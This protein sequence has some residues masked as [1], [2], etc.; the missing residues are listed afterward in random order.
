MDFGHRAYATEDPRDGYPGARSAG[1][2]GTRGDDAYYGMSRRKEEAVHAEQGFNSSLDRRAAD[3]AATSGTN[4][5][6]A[7]S[8]RAGQGSHS[9]ESG[10]GV[11]DGLDRSGKGEASGARAGRPAPAPARA[12]A[13]S[14]ILY[15]A[16][17]VCV[18]AG[19]YISWHLGS[20]GGGQGG[21]IAG[22]ALMVAAVARLVLPGKLAGL[23]ASRRRVTDAVTLAAF[24][25]CLLAVGLVLPGL[26]PHR[27][28]IR[29]RENGWPANER[30]TRLICPKSGW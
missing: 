12:G 28:A 3:P 11:G 7:V 2:A 14:L 23:L 8:E 26:R 25:A 1:S 19:I 15:L 18:V 30:E 27:A 9:P 17:L 13:E 29:T 5:T 20:R 22:G 10:A 6:V 4:V 24:G 21:V 16:V